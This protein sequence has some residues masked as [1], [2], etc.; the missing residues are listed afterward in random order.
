MWSMSDNPF[1]CE[2]HHKKWQI[3]THLGHKLCA[4]CCQNKWMSSSGS[5]VINNGSN[6]LEQLSD[7]LRYGCVWTQSLIGS[8]LFNDEE[9]H[10]FVLS[11]NCL[12]NDNNNQTNTQTI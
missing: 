7:S 9:R 2:S 10:G 12:I 1:G 3:V 6:L 11:I 8:D 5:H 4:K